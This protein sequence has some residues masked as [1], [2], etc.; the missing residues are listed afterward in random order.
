M[1]L[2]PEKKKWHKLKCV[3]TVAVGKLY[4]KHELKHIKY[5]I[6]LLHEY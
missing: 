4:S 3:Q 1:A 6:T 5:I 2:C